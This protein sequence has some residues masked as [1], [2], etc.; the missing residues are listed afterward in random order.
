M[1]IVFQKPAFV[2]VTG[3]S[4]RLVLNGYT[5]GSGLIDWTLTNTATATL[6]LDFSGLPQVV[7][8]AIEARQFDYQIEGVI[9]TSA[10]LVISASVSF[11][12]SGHVR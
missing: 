11:G 3:G 7:V 4:F 1:T 5:I 10:F 12:A 6:C 9:E 2:V 8:D